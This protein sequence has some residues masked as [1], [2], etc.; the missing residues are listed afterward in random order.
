MKLSN[1]TSVKIVFKLQMISRASIFKLPRKYRNNRV[2]R[3][4]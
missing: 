4:N 2:L 3:S 1:G